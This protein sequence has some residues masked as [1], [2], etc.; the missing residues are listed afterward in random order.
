MKAGD[1]KFVQRTTVVLVE[2]LDNNTNNVND[3]RDTVNR[4]TVLATEERLLTPHTV[5]DTIRLVLR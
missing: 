5:A 4:E 2:C 1:K 3:A